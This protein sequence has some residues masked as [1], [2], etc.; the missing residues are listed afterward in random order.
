MFRRVL[1]R[2]G[3][4]VSVVGFGGIIVK[5]ETTENAA[6]YVEEAINRG[7]NYF[8]VAPSYGNAEDMLGPALEPFRKDVVLSC[9]TDALEKDEC[10]RDIETS[11]K[12][13]KTNYFDLYQFHSIVSKEEVDKIFSAGG[14]MEAV[15]EAKEKNLI[16]NIGFSAHTEEAAFELIKRFDFD[17]IMFPVNWA[18]W[19]KEG[20]GNSV[21]DLAKKKN[22]GIIALK[23]LAKRKWKKGEERNWSKPWYKPV[24]NYEEAKLGLR[25]TLSKGVDTAV[26]PGHMELLRWACDAADEY[27]PLSKTEEDYLREKAKNLENDTVFPHPDA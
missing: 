4:E 8:D 6:K 18:S 27:E 5:D 1:G 25:F 3:L 11:L 26:S 16:N 14:A 9:K 22:M 13:L 7:V 20:F 19:L 23:A 10:W 15:L 12:K 17:T 24:E 2:S 21:L